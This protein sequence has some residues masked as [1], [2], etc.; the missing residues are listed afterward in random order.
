MVHAV[1]EHPSAACWLLGWRHVFIS[2]RRI[3]YRAFGFINAIPLWYMN[4]RNEVQ[5]FSLEYSVLLRIIILN[6]K[7]RICQSIAT[8]YIYIYI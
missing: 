1:Q 4:S 6:I 7:D 5:T 8:I 2:R 3:N